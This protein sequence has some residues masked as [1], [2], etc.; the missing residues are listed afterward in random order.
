MLS[1]KSESNDLLDKHKWV[2]RYRNKFHSSIPNQ[3]FK[4]ILD[5]NLFRS[6]DILPFL[7]FMPE[8]N[9]LRTDF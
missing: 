8:G 3:I 2:Y 4:M 7:I 6:G 9:P 5:Y 1:A